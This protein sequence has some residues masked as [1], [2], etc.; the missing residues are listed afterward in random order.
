L[1]ISG[2]E[3]T[4]TTREHLKAMHEKTAEFHIAAAKHHRT[5][6]KCF[7]KTEGIE[8]ASDIEAA[9]EGI[10]Q[11]HVDLADFHVQCSKDLSASMKAAGMDNGDQIAPDGVS[12]VITDFSHVRAFPRHG[13]PDLGKV[14]VPQEFAHLVKVDDD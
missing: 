13:S 6:A 2:K 12:A 3:E 11:Q 14:D 10:A 7:G 4:M 1:Q 5:L 8:S 9:H